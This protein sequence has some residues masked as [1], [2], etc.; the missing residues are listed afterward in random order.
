MQTI[1]TECADGVGILS[2]DR[3]ERWNAMDVET[4]HAFRT[5]GL[6]LARDEAVRAVVVRGAPGV[7]CSGADLRYVREGG[8]AGDLGYLR[9]Q[10]R[11]AALVG[12]CVA[13][14]AGAIVLD[15]GFGRRIVTE[16]EGDLVPRIC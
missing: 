6:R 8:L 3:P 11:D 2:I 9:P 13:E 4:A 1:R 15:T 7:F 14:H 12:T 16:P 10:G 5:A